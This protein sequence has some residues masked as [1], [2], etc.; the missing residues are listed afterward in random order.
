MSSPGSV[1]SAG[2]IA[3]TT[4]GG[5]EAPMRAGAPRQAAR[6]S[7]APEVSL[8]E[9]GE[10]ASAFPTSP[11]DLLTDDIAQPAS[12]SSA[13]GLAGALEGDDDLAFAAMGAHLGG[14]GDVPEAAA[15]DAPVEIPADVAMGE[16]AGASE[17]V[18]DVL[19]MLQRE[20][21]FEAPSGAAATWA[22]RTEAKLDRTKVGFWI[23][24]AWVIV[25]G[26]ATGGYFGLQHYIAQQH[27]EAARLVEQARTEARAG[28]HERLVDAERHL[29]EA[30]DLDA[31][32]TTNPTLLLFVHSQ[33]ALEDGAFEVGYVRPAIDRGARVGAE[34]PYLDAA[35]AVVALGDGDLPG[36]RSAVDTALAAA[37]EDPFILYVAGRVGQRLGSEQALTQLETAVQR[38]P[39]LACAAIALSE[40]RHDEGRHE[41]AMALL[42]AVLTHDDHNLRARLWQAYFQAD[43]VEVEP[44]LTALRELEPRLEHGAP[45]D[46][47]LLQLTR[48]RL[49]RR[50]GR[51][52]PAGAA[53]E[54]ALGAGAQEPRLLGLVARAAQAEGQLLEAEMAATAAVRGSPA[55]AEL[56]KLLASIYLD[57]RNG[58]R[59]LETLGQLSANDPDVLVMTARASLLIGTDEALVG[60]TAALDAFIAEH[61]DASVEVR[62][63]RLRLALL[64]LDSAA[65]GA[66]AQLRELLT[67]AQA[68]GRDNPGDPL[69]ALALGEVALRAR[70]AEAATRALETVVA[71]SPEDAE[72]HYLLGRARRLRGDA[73]GARQ[74]FERAVAL[75]SE[76]VEARLALAQILLDSGDY[77]A[78]EPMYSELSHVAGSSNGISVALAG[79]LGRVEALIGLARLDDANVQLEGVRQDERDLQSV[80]LVRAKLAVAQRRYGDAIQAIRPLA[81]PE[82]APASVVSLYGDALLGVGETDA[83]IEAFERALTLDASSPEALIGRADLHVRGDHGRDALSLLDRAAEALEQRARPP[84][85]RARM[86]MLRGRAWLSERHA[87]EARDAL[88]EASEIPGAPAETWFWLGESLSS[89]NAAQAREAYQHYLDSGQ[90]DDTLAGRARRAIR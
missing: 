14:D 62:A 12:R 44:G 10:T 57:R 28:D 61:E 5:F 84:A 11:G 88:R 13:G 30:R 90:T 43:E 36:A 77:A 37:P 3:S 45:T 76:H 48:A 54:A 85:L 59:A 18:D 40:A 25:L 39:E 35:R 16:Q 58:R 51:H 20:G 47:V 52:E 87:P 70:D 21:I 15:D 74:S 23:A 4:P 89:S 68:L 65:E 78:A 86:L 69:A 50:A 24:G 31:H 29:R 34:A 71:A 79:R 8:L 80:N 7:T 1:S 72:G 73:A 19:A 26:L 38:D 81:E 2:V 67:A 64:T 41:D 75:R 6:K 63:L 82:T 17:D 55:N 32:A 27:A 49:E 46:V 66:D 53:V 9:G 60:A 42:A 56:R 33:R 22:T 83:A